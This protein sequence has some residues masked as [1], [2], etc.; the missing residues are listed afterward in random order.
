LD[1]EKVENDQWSQ[2][3]QTL[4]RDDGTDEILDDLRHATV[5]NT[6]SWILEDPYFQAWV[7]NK[8]PIISIFGGDQFGKSH[9]AAHIVKHF[10][11]NPFPIVAGL[12]A[13]TLSLGYYFCNKEKPSE[14]SLDKILR[15]IAWQISENDPVFRSAVYSLCS[16]RKLGNRHLWNLFLEYFKQGSLDQSAY[17]F[18]DGLD[19]VSASDRKNLYELL[20]QLAFTESL[21]SVYR[22]HILIVSRKETEDEMRSRNISHRMVSLEV[23]AEKTE[24]DVRKYVRN[25]VQTESRLRKI[26]RD[27]LSTIVDRLSKQAE[28]LFT[29]VDLMIDELG[30]LSRPSLIR[31][32]LDDPPP[33]YDLLCL[34]LQ[35]FAD[36]H[37]PEEKRDLNLFLAWV[38]CKPFTPY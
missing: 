34:R 24:S 18:I 8:A 1:P 16:S 36:S 3:F 33:L 7:E 23:T 20:E 35:R 11:D 2:L 4:A 21:D 37:K 6:C 9:L 38:V 5:K 15:T 14:N 27:L 17:F 22:M 28:G 31:E 13:S 26:G 12:G 25:C 32:K 10:Q 30:P 19:L 29:Y